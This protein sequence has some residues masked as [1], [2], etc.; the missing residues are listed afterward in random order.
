M[1]AYTMRSPSPILRIAVLLVAAGSAGRGGLWAYDPPAGAET[2]TALLSPALLSGGFS[3]ASTDSPVADLVNPAGSALLQ[4]MTLDVAYTA[5]AGLG[6]ESGFGNVFNLAG[7]LPT[8]YGVWTASL[9]LIQSGFTS[10]PLGTV[11]DARVGMSKDLFRNLFV[12]A[13]LE[14]QAGSNGAFGWGLNLDLGVIGLLGDVAFLDDLTWGASLRSIGKAYSSTA[15]V[16]ISGNTPASSYDSP[17]TPQFGGRAGLLTVE[18]ADLVLSGNADLWFPSFQNVVFSTGLRL[19][20]GT[21]GFARLGWDFNLREALS[22]E[23]QGL[24]PSLGFGARFV[25]DR[26]KD[27]SFISKTGLNRSE[28]KPSLAVAQLYNNIWA[29]GMGVN[30]PVGV[31]DRVPPV[32]TVAWP[33]TPL[34]A[35]YMSPNNDGV[36]DDV[37]L[38]VTIT[39]QRYVQRF[40]LKVLDERGVVVRTI[41]NKESRPENQDLKGLYGRL[42]YVRKGVDVPPELVWNGMTD[43]GGLAPDGT[44]TIV[45]E[46]TD[47]NGNQTVTSPWKIVVDTVPPSVTATGPEGGSDAFIF[48]PDGDGNKDQ[49]AIA[50]SG[51]TEDR[52][53]GTVID[54]A[55]T[56]VRVWK[57][58]ATGPGALV[59]DGK[60]DDGRVVPDGVYAYRIYAIDRAGNRGETSVEN[61][62]INTQQP[63]VGV[64]IDMAAFSPDGDGVKDSL[65]LTP[66]VPVRVGLDAWKLSVLDATGTE[67]WGLSGTGSQSLAGTYSFNGRNASGAA[68]PEGTYRTR[69]TV[70]YVNGHRPVAY[71]PSFVIDRTPPTASASVDRAAFNPLGDADTTVR[72]AQAASSED[73]WTGEIRPATAA[74]IATA[75]AAAAGTAGT[76]GGSPLSGPSPGAGAPGAAP[77]KAVK[78]WS[79]VGVPDKEITWDGYDDAGRVVPDGAYVYRLSATDKAG[80]RVTASTTAFLVDTQNKEV[81]LSLDARAFSPDGNGKADT[82]TLMPASKAVAAVASWTVAVV[83]TEARPVRRFSGTGSLPAK[84]VWDGKTDAGGKAPDGLYHAVLDVNY[85]TNETKSARSVEM[86]LDTTAPSIEVGAGYTL[87][88]PDGDGRKDTITIVQTSVPGD[89]WEGAVVNRDGMVIR[90]WLWKDQAAS[91][92][93]DGTDAEGNKVPDG[94]YRYQVASSDAAGNAT[95]AFLEN[96]LVDTRPTQAFVTAS[97]AGFSPN[98]DGIYDDLSFGLVVKLAEGIKSWKVTMVDD[99]GTVRRGFGGE[100]S[101]SLPQRL[102]WDGRDDDGRMLQGEF[103]ALFTVDYLKGDHAEARSAP[104]MVDTEGPKVAVSTT[105]K[106]FSPDNDGVDDELKLSLAVVDA[107][108]IDTW[109][110][111]IIEVAVV[112]GGPGAAGSAGARRQ[113]RPFFVWSGRGKPAERLVWD[114]RSQRGELVEAATDYPYRLTITDALGNTTVAEGV[115]AVDV[116]VIRDGDRLKIKVP[117]IVFRPNFADFEGLSQETLD[118]N[119]EVLK[120]IAQILNRFRDYKI[121]VEGHANSVAKISGMSQAAVSRE[122]NVELQ[123]LSTDRAEAVRLKLI[124]FGV[125]ARRLSVAGLGSREPVVPFTD[126]ENRWKNRRVE[127]ILIKQ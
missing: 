120:R 16:G 109:K 117:S 85:R 27:D 37:V 3:A 9:G 11:F 102:A 10:M 108:V 17:F 104:V 91:F 15:A 72:I 77:D 107:G 20:W 22:A 23:P 125:D 83:D 62:I 71:S 78:T 124:E 31:L 90:S 61:I 103:V 98:G 47:D 28:V 84:L 26:D 30:I 7:A 25:I 74:G 80:N 12:G 42:M 52:W 54:A 57:Y 99:T 32:V 44:Y 60:T 13:A 118:R 105:P 65:T 100:G 92:D 69:L 49:F 41:G 19:D 46:A 94:A 121:R 126:A 114:G 24:L 70:T 73:R 127:F 8:P 6:T 113:E 66:A 59:W 58:D 87:F 88:S 1:P 68:L 33:E 96:I 50:Q 116:L 76:S 111:E 14:T 93:W 2:S 40:A 63:P 55:A 4:R 43:A 56:P 35:W 45:I 34:G 29:F 101:V 64:S 67:R 79:F 106:Y 82:V 38:P 95:R 18:A 81:S 39:D 53:T 21:I 89:T 48:S 122:E 36:Q 86:A 123:P 112:E 5:L 75:G 119:A 97:V 115:I 51:S 110:L